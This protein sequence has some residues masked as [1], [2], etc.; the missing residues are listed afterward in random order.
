M[1]PVPLRH[2]PTGRSRTCR[3]RPIRTHRR[4]VVCCAPERLTADQIR[5]LI[6]SQTKAEQ[7]KGLLHIRNLPPNLAYELL[8]LSIETSKNEFI[9]ST[10]AIGLGQIPY[11]PEVSPAVNRSMIDILATDDDYSVRSAAAAGM[12]YVQAQDT[13]LLREALCRALLEDNEWQVRFSCLASLGNIKDPKAIPTLTKYL[14]DPNDLLVQ[15][16]VG[17]LGDIGESESIP[18]LLNLLGSEDMMTRQRLA[19]ALGCIDAA[20]EPSV[21]DALRTL[22]KDQSFVVREAAEESLKTLGREPV[23]GDISD[24]DQLEAEVMNLLEGNETGNAGESA[25]DA[26]RRRLERSFDKEYV[27]ID[28]KKMRNY[29]SSS[30]NQEYERLVKDLKYGECKVRILAAVK[31]R[32]FD[33]SLCLKAL[34]DSDVLNPYASSER[35]RAICVPLLVK[36]GDVEGIIRLQKTDPDQHVR[37]ACCDALVD[38]GGGEEAIAAAIDAFKTDKHWLVRVS[39][40]LALGTIG[41]E[42]TSVEDE[43]IGALGKEGLADVEPPQDKVVRRHV[44]TALGFLGC[45]RAIPVFEKLLDGDDD[46]VRYRIAAAL[47]G[48]HC[49]ES[50]RLVKRL[51]DN[52]NAEVRDMAQCSLDGLSAYEF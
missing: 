26:L 16:A 22:C 23:G 44:V 47:R 39:A 27:S 51:I 11:H 52:G 9:R 33:G 40:V 50:V 19:Q 31:L 45:E 5:T 38:A 41:K 42:D 30:E 28:M 6:T 3:R 10:A 17:A 21:I 8:L 12:G 13:S 49:S 36:G 25:S 34:N 43:L 46:G 29:I 2:Y 24:E 7:Q 15:A 4:S 14:S 35:L 32:Q 18:D 20:E 1:S 37:S 48:I